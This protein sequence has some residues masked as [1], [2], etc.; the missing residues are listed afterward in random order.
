MPTTTPTGAD[1]VR[2]TLRRIKE[3]NPDAVKEFI[4]EAQQK[5]STNR[6]YI[7][8][9]GIVDSGTG[10]FDIAKVLNEVKVSIPLMQIFGIAPRVRATVNKI[11]QPSIKTNRGRKPGQTQ[12]TP[13]PAIQPP[14]AGQVAAMPMVAAIQK[15]PPGGH[16]DH[17]LLPTQVKTP[18]VGYVYAYVE[19]IPTPRCMLDN[20]STMDVISHPFLRQLGLKTRT[21]EQRWKITLADDHVQIIDQYV[22]LDV[23]VGEVLCTLRAFV[24]SNGDAYDV[25]LSQNWYY[26]LRATQCW[27][28]NV[29]TVRGTGGVVTHVPIMP[30]KRRPHPVV[31]ELLKRTPDHVDRPIPQDDD[32][33]GDDD[34]DNF[35][36]DENP[37]FV[38]DMIDVL[39]AADIS[40]KFGGESSENE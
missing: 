31:P 15:L 17:A 20:G 5:T 16:R 6:Q 40:E 19:G 9:Q 25:L 12:V 34:D 11:M 14:N 4:R 26:R 32:E 30:A 7:P 1:D 3:A 13:R 18:S 28:T 10:D 24:M 8:M 23:V 38:F 33:S 22:L 2:E 35:D 37:D 21:S 39:H 29:V 36:W 27:E